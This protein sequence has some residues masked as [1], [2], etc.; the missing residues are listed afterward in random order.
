M[1]REEGAH[2]VAL[3]RGTWLAVSWKE[4]GSGLKLGPSHAGPCGW[5]PGQG[6]PWQILS[7]RRTGCE[8]CI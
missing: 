1:H 7:R 3:P 6:E 5:S 2:C 8:A 4:K